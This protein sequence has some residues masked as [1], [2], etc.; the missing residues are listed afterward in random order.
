M[1]SLTLDVLGTSE[2]LVIR[3][4]DSLIIT[5]FPTS[6]MKGVSC[7]MMFLNAESASDQGC[8]GVF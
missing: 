2:L 1:Q 5:N 7:Y 3:F 6:A 4:R 8:V